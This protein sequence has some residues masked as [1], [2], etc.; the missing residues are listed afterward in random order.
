MK[1]AT[2]YLRVSSSGQV[3][4]AFS[5]EGY[6][7]EMQRETCQRRARELEYEIV[8][9]YVDYGQSARAANRPLFQEL[10]TRIRTAQ[11]VDAVIVFNVS[12]FARNMYDDVTLTVELE[13]L[14]VSVLSATEHFDDSPFGKRMRRYLAADAEFY[15]EDLSVKAKGGLHKKAR[16]GG[17][18]GPAPIGYLNVHR[19]IEGIHVRLVEPD[20]DRAPHLTWAFTAFA[21]GAYTLDTLHAALRE[22]GFVTRQTAKYRAKPIS[23]SHLARLLRNLYYIGIVRYGGVEYEGRHQPLID[24][25]TFSRVQAILDAHSHAKERDRKHHHYLKG[26]LICE[27]CDSPLTFVRARGKKGGIYF[28]FACLGRAKRT[29][30]TLPYLPAA[31]IEDRVAGAYANVKVQQLGSATHRRWTVHI[32]DIRAALDLTIDSMRRQ[33]QAEIRRQE[34]RIAAIKAQQSKLLDAFLDDNL[35]H[36]L[37]AEKQ[38]ELRVELASAE[39]LLALAEQDGIELRSVLHEVLDLA[40]DCEDAYARLDPT[41]RRQLNQAFFDGFKVGDDDIADAPLAAAVASLTARDTP[42]RLRAET[43]QGLFFGA[44]SDKSLTA[45]REGFEPSMELAAPYSL[46]RRVPSATRPPLRAEG[47]V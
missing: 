23:R 17:T 13:R 47:P 6:S 2:I 45:E 8:G 11:D 30:C 34:R 28:Y 24:K 5:T 37:L 20:P 27:R 40:R 42:K 16:H 15:S 10:L 12:R 18:P 3:G 21:T 35:S 1:R 44:G 25:D 31:E 9:E 39:H 33:S 4:R 32:E 41:Y 36:D 14:G 7:I 46:S 19:T 22:R 26:S 29:G 43:R 38:A